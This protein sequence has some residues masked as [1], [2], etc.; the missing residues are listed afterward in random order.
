MAYLRRVLGGCLAVGLTLPVQAKE[1]G[2]IEDATAN[3]QLR[4]YFFSRDYSGIVGANKQSR[5]QEWAQGFILDMRSGYTQGL[6]GVGVD[7]LGLYGV[8]LDSGRGRTNSGLLP[9]HD[10]TAADEYGRL[11][12]ALKLKVSKTEL[13][14]GELRPNLPVL[15]HSDLRLL[16]PTYQGAALVSNEFDGLTLQTGQ[17]RSTSLRDS[18]NSQD[19]YALI[20]DPINPARIARFTSDRF[21]YAGA[22]YS[23]NDNR[24]SVGLWQAQLEDIYQQR[25]YSFKHFEPVGKWVLGLST[26]YF[27]SSDDGSSI[28]GKLDNQAMFALAS[29]KYGGNTFYIG[30]QRIDGDD[31]FI[32][33]GANTNPLGN[34][35]PTY[36]FAAPGERSWQARHDYDFAALGVPGLTSTLRY[37]NGDNVRT[38]RGFEGKDWERDLDLAYVVQ[39]GVLKGVGLRWRNVTARSNYRT[40][41]DEN[42]LILTYTLSLF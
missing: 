6:V 15:V 22:D 25:F 33:I 29:A 39:S 5:T 42:R 1:A 31:G 24:T 38:G 3:V 28:A 8:K 12:A 18:T 16:P 17:M 34:T 9:V 20:N 4:N 32:Q 23:F 7:V 41:I 37:V 40:D 19:M 21:N 27:D 14:V 13:K 2:F 30:H 35:L 10:G 36:E 11:G 26:G